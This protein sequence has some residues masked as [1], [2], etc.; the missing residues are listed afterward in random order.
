M[1]G[2]SGWAKFQ[3][4]LSVNGIS[5]CHVAGRCIDTMRVWLLLALV[6]A[7]CG[8]ELEPLKLD[9]VD[10]LA[11]QVKGVYVSV[12]GRSHRRKALNRQR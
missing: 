2:I 1:N 11:G 9:P 4:E 6:S 8:D 10:V 5:G 7:K 12:E 3:T